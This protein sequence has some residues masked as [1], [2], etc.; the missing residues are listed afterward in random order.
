MSERVKEITKTISENYNL[1]DSLE[2]EIGRLD[3]LVYETK[4]DVVIDVLVQVINQ[5]TTV[6]QSISNENVA[7]T[8]ELLSI[9]STDTEEE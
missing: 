3:N 1:V 2:I 9:L 4:A 8:K 6:K 5:L 7:L